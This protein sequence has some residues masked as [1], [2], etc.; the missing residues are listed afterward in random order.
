MYSSLSYT[1]AKSLGWF[2]TGLPLKILGFFKNDP[3]S[4]KKAMFE[5]A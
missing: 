2:S 5:G 4:L 3:V 1:W